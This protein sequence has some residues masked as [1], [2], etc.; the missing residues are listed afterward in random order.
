MTSVDPLE[1]LPPI[2][3]YGLIGDGRTAALCSSSGSI[4]WMCLPRFD[5]QPIFGRLIGG[6]RA[7]RFSLAVEGARDVTRRYREGSAVLETTWKTPG[8]EVTLT[9]GMTLH[10]TGRLL[11]Q[12]LLV[13]RLDC[14]GAR[15]RVSLTFDP[16]ESLR[17]GTLRRSSRPQGLVV[18]R[19][20]LG[21]ALQSAPEVRVVPGESTDVGIDPGR[22]LTFALSVADRQPL[23]F[24]D[25]DRAFRLLDD[26]D[27][28][29]RAWTSRITYVGP[30]LG[31]VVRSLITLRLLTY[32]PSGA[33]VAAPTT[34]LPEAPDSGR[35]WDYRFSWPRDAAIGATAFLATGH[36]E[37]A[38]SFLHWLLVASRLTRPRLHVAYTMDGKPGL[39]EEEL[40]D[41]PGYRDGRPVRIGNEAAT[42]HQLDVYGWVVDAA[43]ALAESG[44]A[45]HR[46]TWRGVAGFADFVAKN[47]REPDA[48]IWEMREEPAHYVHSK[49]MGWLALDRAL[50]MSTS[51]RTRRG[52]R[53]RWQT[54]RGAL[55]R[56]IRD[57]GFDTE[58]N[59]YVRAYGGKDLD[60]ALLILP[61]L[62]FEPPNSPRVAGTIEAIRRDLSAGRALLYRYPPGSDGLDGEEGAFLPCSFWLVL[63]LARTGRLEEARELFEELC[64]RSTDLGLYAEEMD[65]TSGEH[66][67][68]FP[69][70]LTHGGLIQAALALEAATAD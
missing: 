48:G 3:D 1:P 53:D 37:E 45:L 26:T 62:E 41:V 2:A 11:P 43:S 9:E 4:D 46:A 51:N 54:A 12:V 67:G 49:L 55:A 65:P 63:A 17:G 7:G 30:L 29:W 32:A 35:N 34:S 33:P 42:Q 57:R 8:G 70:A 50:R 31:S 14:R 5:S 27:A 28:W 10:A 16:R 52:R 58:R 69:Q 36:S 59:T 44:T 47:W 23:V 25:A 18:T 15:A 64:S 39:D 38:H 24:V 56:E 40:F 60:A 6:D 22:S 20:S 13:R 21:I 68:N 66:L 61:V 19:G